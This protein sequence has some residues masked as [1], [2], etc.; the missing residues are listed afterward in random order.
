MPPQK[1]DT[2]LAYQIDQYKCTFVA[3]EK[4]ILDN[5]GLD[6]ILAFHL[7]SKECVA[8]PHAKFLVTTSPGVSNS[9]SSEGHIQRKK[10]SP[11]RS[12][13]VKAFAGRNLQKNSK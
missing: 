5:A 12:L 4:I 7:S 8:I 6:R 9:D 2:K 3:N 10:Y 11:G 13:L 1:T